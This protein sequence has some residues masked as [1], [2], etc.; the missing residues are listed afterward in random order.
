MYKDKFSMPVD[1]RE[2]STK[3]ILKKVTPCFA[4]FALLAVILCL[5]GRNI[6]STDVVGVRVFCYALILAV[7]FI[8]WGVPHKMIDKT[9]FAEVQKVWVETNERKDAYNVRT[10]SPYYTVHSVY[11][12]IKRDD[13]KEKLVKAY[14]CRANRHQKLD[15]FKQGDRIFHLYGTDHF[16]KLPKENDTT[17]KYAVCNTSNDIKHRKCHDCGYTLLKNFK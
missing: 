13:G 11:M 6:I 12:I 8:I 7:P 2:Y 15:V 5:W 17:V 3:F 9:H 10:L 1:L 4:V 14:E 16:I